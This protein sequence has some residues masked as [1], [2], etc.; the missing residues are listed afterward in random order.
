MKSFFILLLV[1]N[2]LGPLLP[3]RATAQPVLTISQEDA[4]PSAYD[5]YSPEDPYRELKIFAE[6]EMGIYL[7]DPPRRH[8]SEIT[9][10]SSDHLHFH[11]WRPLTGTKRALWS[12]GAG[13]LVFG[14]I[15][16]SRGARQLFADMPTLKR[17]TLSFHEVIRPDQ[18]G[19]RLGKAVDKI[20]TYLTL[21][22]TRAD[23][24]SLDIERL[25]SCSRLEDCGQEE[26]RMLS[27]VKFN[28]R[29]IK[30]RSR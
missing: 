27:L 13:W 4:F 26:R 25:R 9:Q 28:S 2:S 10:Y 11:V 19:R 14:R 29:Y 7:V 21:S 15:K 16:Y 3:L 20:H 5:L 1:F 8:A 12:T 30:R 18:K 6:E 17:I 22:I 23:F 24:E